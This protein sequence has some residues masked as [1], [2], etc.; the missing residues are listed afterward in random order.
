MCLSPWGLR[1]RM[2]TPCGSGLTTAGRPQRGISVWRLAHGHGNRIPNRNAPSATFSRR[3]THTRARTLGAPIVVM[4]T[5][6]RAWVSCR[7]DWRHRH[8]GRR[9]RMGMDRRLIPHG[10]ALWMPADTRLKAPGRASLSWG[11]AGGPRAPT[12]V[13]PWRPTGSRLL[14]NS[15]WTHC[16][17]IRQRSSV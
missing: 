7:R 3:V 16:G 8:R 6:P 2:R 10:V 13:P 17:G 15:W 11:E 5:M 9:S 4:A 12:M 1:V 14:P